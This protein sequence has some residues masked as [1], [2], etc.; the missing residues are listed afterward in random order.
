M[1][2]HDKFKDLGNTS[3]FFFFGGGGGGGGADGTFHTKVY[4]WAIAGLVPVTTRTV[5]IGPSET[6]CLGIL[7]LWYNSQNIEIYSWCSC[8]SEPVTVQCSKQEAQCSR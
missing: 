4:F 5:I 6:P 2:K 1:S 3:L 7:F 8:I